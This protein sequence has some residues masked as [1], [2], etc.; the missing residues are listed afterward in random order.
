[1]KTS[2]GIQSETSESGSRAFLFFDLCAGRND[3]LVNDYSIPEV[4]GNN[5]LS[6]RRFMTPTSF[7]LVAQGS[8][9]EALVTQEPGGGQMVAQP[10]QNLSQ[11]LP[12]GGLA[13]TRALCYS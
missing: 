1:M 5:S 9:L 12:I 7:E 13:T 11:R 3:A 8:W 2:G 4:R 6:H 10:L